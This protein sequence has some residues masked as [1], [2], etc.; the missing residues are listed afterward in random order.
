MSDVILLLMLSTQTYFKLKSQLR[1]AA[2]YD[3]STYIEFELRC[4][5]RCLNLRYRTVL[6]TIRPGQ[7]LRKSTSRTTSYVSFAPPFARRSSCRTLEY[8]N[9]GPLCTLYSI[10]RTD[11]R[12]STNKAIKNDRLEPSCPSAHRISSPLARSGSRRQTSLP[13]QTQPP[14]ATAAP[15]LSVTYRPSGVPLTQRNPTKPPAPRRAAS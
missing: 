10:G 5:L 7:S 15:R 9:V 8:N 12:Y 11:R 3:P 2:E 1:L 14:R 13:R 6:T 4:N